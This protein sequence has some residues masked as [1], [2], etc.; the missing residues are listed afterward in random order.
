[1][2]IA[3]D[4]RFTPPADSHESLRTRRAEAGLPPRT[5]PKAA[6]PSAGSPSQDATP[7]QRDAAG[8]FAKGNAGG[9]GNPF[10]R[11][12]AALRAR[13]L[14]RVTEADMDDIAVTLI[15]LAKTGDLAAIKLLFQYILGKP[16]PAVDP[17]RLD[18][19]ELNLVH[20]IRELTRDVFDLCGAPPSDIIV[21]L[22]RLTQ[23]LHGNKLH[24]EALKDLPPTDDAEPGDGKAPPASPEA[25][26]PPAATAKTPAKT[27]AA[28]SSAPS[29]DGANGNGRPSTHGVNGPQPKKGASRHKPSV[30][31][32]SVPV[33]FQGQERNPVPHTPPSTHGPDGGR[34]QEKQP[35]P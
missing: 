18:L 7:P 34:G 4:S 19:E 5:K 29:T 3:L 6:K 23:E 30:G 22:V 1:M 26:P 25:A 2:S 11:Q 13:L 8:R 32:D 14:G 28:K 16:A 15:L 12:V 9:Q 33:R 31:Q 20:L 35:K 21:G 27:P 17:D 10:A 24:R